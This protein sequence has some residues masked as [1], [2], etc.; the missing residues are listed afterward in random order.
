MRTLVGARG[1]LAYTTLHRK[2]SFRGLRLAPLLFG[3]AVFASTPPAAPVI[4]EPEHDRDVVAPADVHM[5]TA[6]FADED[7]DG[8]LCS[9]WEIVTLEEEAAWRAGC[10]AGATRLHIHMADGVF[11]SARRELQASR[12]YRLRVRHR[13]DSGDADT[14]WSAWSEREFRTS[15]PP[16]AAPMRIRDILAHPA[17]AWNAT[18]PRGAALRVELVDD[19]RLLDMQNGVFTDKEPAPARSAIRIALHAGP[20][21]WVVPRSELTFDD[22]NGDRRT[23]YIPEVFV[24]ENGTARF[25][26]AANGGTHHTSEGDRV[27][28][29]DQIARGASVPW[30]ARERG[31]VIDHVA[32]GLQLPL[33][34]AFAPD[35]SHFYVAELYGDVKAVTRDG[36]VSDFA[37]GLLDFSPEGGIPGSGEVGLGGITVDP[38]NGDVLVTRVAW[39]DQ[40][41]GLVPQV[42]RL[43]NGTAETILSLPDELQA[44]SHQISKVTIG[45]DRKLYVHFGDT[46]VPEYAR[47]MTT[48]RGKIVRLNLDGSVPEDN[49]FYDA[50]DGVDAR[51][52]I[53]ASGFRNPFGGAW[54]AADRSLYE[55]ENGPAV[56]RFARVVAGRDYGWDGTNASMRTHALY[57]W[58][59]AVAPVQVAFVQRETFDGSG[60]PE[61]QLDT[62]FVSESGPTWANGEQRNGKRISAIA[63]DGDELAGTSR[64]F[65]EY[66][67]TGRATVSAVTAGPDGLYFTDLYKD[68]HY[69]SPLDRGANVFRV[70][71]AGYADFETSAVSADGRTVAFVDRSLVPGATTRTWDFGDG[72]SSSES[73]PLHRFGRDGTYIVRLTVNGTIVETKKLRVGAADGTLTGDYFDDSDFEV[74]RITRDES[75]L[76]LDW[77]AAAPFSARWRGTLRP[78]YSETYR[79]T[80]RTTAAVRLLL[81][82][83]VIVPD[84]ATSGEVELEAGSD[85]ELVVELRHRDGDA[86]IR[87]TWESDSQSAQLVPRSAPPVEPGVT[88]KRRSVRR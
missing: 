23:V 69:T 76:D 55:V 45:P 20:E 64:P 58:Q 6:P 63:F 61:A 67:G 66:N 77:G 17:P 81:D 59:P 42:V 70:R 2:V 16:S 28:A 72:Q 9:D 71:W 33:D 86:S 32:G 79:F 83:E 11:A 68:S 60:F 56:D 21:P 44:A 3:A 53:F 8:H 84:D 39:P 1:G 57:T 54:R 73:H 41:S 50:S 31:Y 22:E 37:T 18:P 19:V 38:E 85:H 12:E 82:G 4:L 5:V 48:V 15:A 80:V 51:D 14:E 26:V 87:V 29:F 52:L 13:D 36:V 27:P 24:S 49:P 75:L 30:T 34:L 46:Q 65:V 62:A 25:W 40:T 47:D 7:G 35:G 74:H 78:R 88:T 10:A 43:S